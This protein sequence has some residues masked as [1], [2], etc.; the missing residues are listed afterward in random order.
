MSTLR[1]ALDDYLAIRRALGYRLQR[2]GLLL[3]D[4]VAHMETNGADAITTDAANSSLSYWMAGD[5]RIAAMP[6]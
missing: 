3:A 6:V 1:R 2:T 5:I 4:F